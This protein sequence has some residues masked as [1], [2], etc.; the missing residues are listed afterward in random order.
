[1][2]IKY[3]ILLTSLFASAV[4]CADKEPRSF[5]FA[6]EGADPFMQAREHNRK[7][8]EQKQNASQAAAETAVKSAAQ[9][10][11]ENFMQYLPADHPSNSSDECSGQETKTETETGSGQRIVDCLPGDLT[12]NLILPY[13]FEVDGSSPEALCESLTDYILML[14]AKFQEISEQV[15]MQIK[16]DKL[17]KKCLE[18]KAF[19]PFQ[20]KTPEQDKI[21]QGINIKDKEDNTALHFAA[22]R[23]YFETAEVLIA[24]DIDINALARED[25]ACVEELIELRGAPVST[26]NK[27]AIKELFANNPYEDHQDI[28]M[29][30]LNWHALND[31]LLNDHMN[32]VKLILKNKNI[33]RFQSAIIGIFAGSLLPAEDKGARYLGKCMSAYGKRA[34]EFSQSARRTIMSR[35]FNREPGIAI[36]KI[37]RRD[38][39]LNNLIQEYLLDLDLENGF[40]LTD[41]LNSYLQN[42]EKEEKKETI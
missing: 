29:Q 16:R 9:V 25:I 12:T 2:K 8:E 3:L 34:G 5:G 33:A 7:L 17:V 20:L 23:G 24:N 4:K 35:L 21:L 40:S 27:K 13:G 42:D 30:C 19:G 14:R 31:A 22:Q 18:E 1:M 15:I 38:L 41:I 6:N 36:V 28:Q 10:T 37:A 26:E 11:S 39:N 32:I